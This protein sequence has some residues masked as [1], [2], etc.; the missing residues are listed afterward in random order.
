LLCFGSHPLSDPFSAA[1]FGK[2]SPARQ[3][4]SPRRPYAMIRVYNAAGNLFETHEHKGDF[5]EW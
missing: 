4:Q 5:K 2:I 1:E 3:V